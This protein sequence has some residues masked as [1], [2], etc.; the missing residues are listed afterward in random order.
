VATLYI[1][2]INN[3]YNVHVTDVSMISVA[4]CVSNSRPKALKLAGP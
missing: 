4:P 2:F 3:Q 1:G